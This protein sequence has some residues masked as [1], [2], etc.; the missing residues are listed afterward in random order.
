[1]HK[2]KGPTQRFREI[3]RVGESIFFYKVSFLDSKPGVHGMRCHHFCENID[4][5]PGIDVEGGGGVPFYIEK[6]I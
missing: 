4:G 2:L 1:M 3:K 6:K 5:W